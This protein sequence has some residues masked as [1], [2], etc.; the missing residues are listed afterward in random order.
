[1]E[2]LEKNSGSAHW[3]LYDLKGIAC[4]VCTGYA[5]RGSITPKTAMAR[6]IE[7]EEKGR[8]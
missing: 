2:K 5:E 8:R 7:L 3:T 1:M 4:G 6:M